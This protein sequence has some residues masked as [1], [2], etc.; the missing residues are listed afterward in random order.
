MVKAHRALRTA[1]PS[2]KGCFPWSGHLLPRAGTVKRMKFQQ[3]EAHPLSQVSLS[4]GSLVLA[5]PKNRVYPGHGILPS[6]QAG[7]SP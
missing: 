7:M 3:Q 1:L 2:C 6:L 5:A 4:L